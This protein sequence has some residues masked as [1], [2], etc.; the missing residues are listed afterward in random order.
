MIGAESKYRHQVRRAAVFGMLVTSR[1]A[2]FLGVILCQEY[3]QSRR[4]DFRC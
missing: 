2:V 4:G 3:L 1:L